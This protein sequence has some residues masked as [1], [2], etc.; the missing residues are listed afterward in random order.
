M[1]VEL[2]A[3]GIKCLVTNETGVIVE[4][5]QAA[6][7]G[8]YLGGLVPRCCEQSA[9]DNGDEGFIYLVIG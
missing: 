9:C 3:N 7:S 1:S 8:Q 6:V 2:I 5:L 4:R